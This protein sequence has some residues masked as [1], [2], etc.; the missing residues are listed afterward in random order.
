[1]AAL[2]LVRSILETFVF[3]DFNR[4]F[5]WLRREE[6]L[7]LLMNVGWFESSTS[8]RDRSV[9]IVELTLFYFFLSPIWLLWVLVLCWKTAELFLS[10]ETCELLDLF[11]LVSPSLTELC[12]GISVKS[13]TD[14]D[15]RGLRFLSLSPGTTRNY[16]SLGLA[17]SPG[18][19]GSAR[20]TGLAWSAGIV[21]KW[22]Q[23]MPT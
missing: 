16:L 10:L 8:F 21:Y 14:D 18:S 4:F 11:T 5:D 3:C 6:L 1:M 19:A 12:V 9:T 7:I 15:D 20:L 13:L 22:F 2:V 23:D 17:W